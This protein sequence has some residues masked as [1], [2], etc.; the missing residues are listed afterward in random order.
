MIFRWI[1]SLIAPICVAT[2]VALT[3]GAPADIRAQAG[4]LSPQAGAPIDLTGTWVSLVSEDWHLRMVTP[5]KG[6]YSGV[7]LNDEGRRVADGWDPAAVE[8]AGEECKAYAAPAILRV[9]T[10]LN[11]SWEADTTLRMDTDAGMQTRSFHFSV[12]SPDAEPTW[13]GHSVAEWV[14]TGGQFG[15]PGGGHLKVTTTHLRPGYLRKNGVP[16]SENGVMTEYF[17]NLSEP[18]G[19][20]LLF[21][22]TIFEDPQYL[23]DPLAMSQQFKKLPDGSGWNPMPCTAR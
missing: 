22:V 6:D 9:P 7:P 21:V 12:A 17:Y 1:P 3:F 14:V 19:D 4:D 16:Y 23:T 10:R 8:A 13:Q 15:V 11:I 20:T 18:N 5:A 2:V